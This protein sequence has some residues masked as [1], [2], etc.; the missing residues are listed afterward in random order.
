MFPR[1]Q[2]ELI[3]FGQGRKLER[4]GN[5][6]LDRPAPVTDSLTRAKPAAWEQADGRFDRLDGQSGSWVWHRPPP[7]DWHARHDRVV[8]HLKPT[9]FGHIGL[10][11]EQAACWDLIGKQLAAC[12]AQPRV[13]NLFAYTGG[14]TLAA[15]AAGAAVVHID[16]AKNIV[17]W[18]R[19]N[20]DASDLSGAP[21]RWIVED[22]RRFVKRELKRGNQYDAIILDPPSYAHG[23]RGESWTIED[24]LPELL[25]ECA[26]LL[27]PHFCFLLLTW[28]SPGLNPDHLHRLLV[29]ASGKRIGVPRSGPLE[30][31][32][33]T[34]RRLPS[35]NRL[36]WMPR[37]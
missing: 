15:A 6:L 5:Y 17:R 11:P 27:R 12:A 4:F 35:G 22:A 8:L 9:A 16:A 24:Q 30:L 29:D 36:C 18:A 26:A 33:T 28:H 34:D 3:D 23:P 1:D 14:S 7:D 2:Y 37:E 10:F 32:T 21:I 25:A 31:R 20:A 13:L 19:R